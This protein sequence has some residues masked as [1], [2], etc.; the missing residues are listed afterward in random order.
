MLIIFLI[1]FCAVLFSG[2]KF[3]FFMFVISILIL[4]ILF[5]RSK[6]LIFVMLVFCPLVFLLFFKYSFQ[7]KNN[8]GGFFKYISQV[9]IYTSSVIENIRSGK[10]IEIPNVWIKEMHNGIVAFNTK[11]IFG[12]GIKS[13]KI[14]CPKI[15][16]YPCNSHPHQS[17]VEM[18]VS[19]GLAGYLLL[20]I[21]FVKFSYSIFIKNYHKFNRNDQMLLI[22]FFTLT[23]IEAFPLRTT[24]SFFSTTNASYF[25]IIMSIYISLGLK[26][27]KKNYE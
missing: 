8:F 5:I 3:P 15:S 2:N 20:L 12:G 17:H 24:G 10:E 1:T 16:K 7:V 4:F 21:L 14:S 13:Y 23:F 9:E 26:K 19:V 22:L 18:L 27:L 6:K 11:K 25:F